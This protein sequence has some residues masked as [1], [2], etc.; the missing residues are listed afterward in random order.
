MAIVQVLSG[1]AGRGVRVVVGLGLVAIGVWLVGGI[2][3]WVLA[4]IGLVP[5]AAG[6]FDFCV[7][8]PFFG[9]GFKG[10]DV[11]ANIAKA[12]QKEKAKV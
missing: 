12:N 7:L 9:L 2:A 10:P 4:V 6:V 11:R 1:T 3:G 5:I 8:A